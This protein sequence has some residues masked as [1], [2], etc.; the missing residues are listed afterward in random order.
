MKRAYLL[1]MITGFISCQVVDYRDNE[2]ISSILSNK[3]IELTNE[4]FLCLS[5]M[6]IEPNIDSLSIIDLVS[7]YAKHIASISSSSLNETSTVLPSKMKI[8]E[9]YHVSNDDRNTSPQLSICVVEFSSNNR[10][11]RAYIAVNTESPKILA[12]FPSW[13]DSSSKSSAKIMMQIAQNTCLEDISHLKYVQDSLRKKVVHKIS[14]SLGLPEERIKYETIKD[15]IVVK[16]AIPTTR[17][18]INPSEPSDVIQGVYPLI[19][20]T[21]NRTAF[22]YIRYMPS[23]PATNYYAE[24]N[25]NVMAAAQ[26]FTLYQPYVILTSPGLYPDWKYILQTP[27]IFEKDPRITYDAPIPE[28][29]PEDK[30]EF[31]GQMMKQISER[32]GVQTFTDTSSPTKEIKT[33]VLASNVKTFLKRYYSFSEGRWNTDNVIQ[34]LNT[35]NPVVAFVEISDENMVSKAEHTFLIDGY[36]ICQKSE[37][38]PQDIYL[39]VNEGIGETGVGYFYVNRN[40]TVNFEIANVNYP[41]TSDTLIILYNI[42]W[43]FRWLR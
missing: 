5:S 24:V 10:I 12:F 19:I 43:D 31:M 40:K 26:L 2:S 25:P 33:G 30:C 21:W 9:K 15:N 36:L 14:N 20:T 41:L 13:S 22:P 29:D 28:N 11:G 34:T 32:M 4:E 37:D 39:H 35:M 38:A 7:G 42:V 27:S 6:G 3:K 23:N 1:L 8:V 18:I 16:D 17:S